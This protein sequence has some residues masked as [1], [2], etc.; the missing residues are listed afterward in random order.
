MRASEFSPSREFLLTAACC[1]W[2]IDAEKMEAV[3]VAASAPLDWSRFIRI[4]ERHRVV[5][6]V[7]SALALA[8][9][10]TPAPFKNYIRE[11]ALALTRENLAMA[12]ESIRLR[13][14]FQKAQI[15][16]LFVKGI[17]LAHIAYGNIGV[18]HSKDIDLLIAREDIEP[19]SN[20]LEVSGYRRSEP[21]PRLSD[22]QVR[23]L[24][25]LRKNSSFIHEETE[26][27]IE[28]HWRLFD[29]RYM[30]G[31]ITV[32]S[33]Q[34]SVT[35][36]EGANIPTL[37][38][39]DLFAY[40]CAHG[41]SDGWF[42]LKWLADITALLEKR[43]AGDIQ[44][45]FDA[46]NERGAGPAAS[47]ALLLCQR[48]L[49]TNL[50]EALSKSLQGNF[51]ARWLE[52]IGLW[53]MRTGNEEIALPDVAFGG[54]RIFFSH[55]LLGRGWRHAIAELRIFLTNTDDMLLLRLPENL[56]FLY[57]ILRLPLWAL[58]RLFGR[59]GST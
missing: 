1:A 43:A 20:L 14:Q 18:R 8:Q 7:N 56:S 44:L 54:T 9:V 33:A 50:P 31:D 28:L 21:D 35:I 23:S 2:P 25:R 39:E 10:E 45:L 36:A 5:G 53:A 6:L 51:R 26:H 19:A 30:L 47:Q 13:N 41:A 16:L 29:N 22:A 49:T 55:F 24:R 3:R 40:L 48:L 57:P 59:S 37:N 27:E 32:M 12:A 11:Q 34:H 42:R 52:R 58:R 15:P 4:V 17:T 38:D 46:A